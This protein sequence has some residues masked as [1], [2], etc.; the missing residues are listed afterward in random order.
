MMS[1]LAAWPVSADQQASCSTISASLCRSSSGSCVVRP[2]WTAASWDRVC[3]HLPMRSD[4]KS[5]QG[6][7]QWQGW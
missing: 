4:S 2:P 1:P 6:V 5:L 7:C 3:S